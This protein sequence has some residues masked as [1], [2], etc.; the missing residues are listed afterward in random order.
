MVSARSAP[1]CERTAMYDLKALLKVGVKV[2]VRR[3]NRDYHWQ[4]AAAAL[5]RGG[6]AADRRRGGRARS[7]YQSSR[8]A[9][10]RLSEP[11]VLL[12]S[13]G[14]RRPAW[15]ARTDRLCAGPAAGISAGDDDTARDPGG[16]GRQRRSRH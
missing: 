8:D 14:S 7:L 5:E 10:R 12:A 15:H 6:E 16:I 2:D 4:G 13:P 3:S 11:A 9:P 1:P